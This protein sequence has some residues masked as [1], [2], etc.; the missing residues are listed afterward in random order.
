M[1]LVIAA[2]VCLGLA[3]ASLVLPTGPT[4]DP[5]AWL[6]WGRDLAHLGLSTTGGGTSWKPLPAFVDAALTPL[7]QGAADGW[8][9]VARAG[10]LFAVFMAFRL[11]WRLAPRGGRVVA[12]LVAAAALV[13]THEWLVRNGLGEAEGL[14]VAFCL[15]AVDRHLDG[16]RMQA[17]AL[18]V[19]AGL[20]RVEVWPFVG[21]Y[22]G[23][24][25]WT[26]R[27]WRVRTLLLAGALALPLIWFGG[28]L[29]GSGHLTTAMDRAL[30]RKAGTPG[31][32]PHPVHALLAEAFTMV[33][34]PA[35]A[36][37]AVAVAW[38]A[39]RRKRVV[40]VLAAGAALWT[41]IV[42]V[43]TARGY[44]GLP[45][46]L[47]VAC[48]LEAVLAGIG[49]ALLV[50]RRNAIIAAAVIGAFV[51]AS[52]PNAR[53]LPTEAKSIDKVAD[54][55]GVLAQTV[56]EAGG[57]GAVTRCGE[58]TT[59]WYTVTALAYDLDVPAAQVRHVKH[60][61]ALLVACSRRFN[62]AKPA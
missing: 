35:W 25:A 53:L 54:M 18:L 41:A 58:P 59:R 39:V 21:L 38:A 26:T 37:A 49:A 40:L 36:L 3:L 24:L 50:Q 48:A 62:P 19:A 44:A 51:F 52:L 20:V 47:F 31:A 16:H 17:F 60:G 28:D 4:Y 6:I 56:S 27:S 42:A 22:G 29:L 7:G 43:M 45:R 30:H 23:W 5:Y 8:V 1:A 34:P 14:M 13:L 55:D 33:P 11:A 61:G 46:F 10:A 32:S 57:A 9:V 2:A 12:G 15:L